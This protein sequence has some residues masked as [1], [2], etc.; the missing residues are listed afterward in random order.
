MS[1]ETAVNETENDVEKAVDEEVA[2][3]SEPEPEQ[4]TLDEYFA[5]Q[6]ADRQKYSNNDLFKK[7]DERK[8]DD[9]DL[10]RKGTAHVKKEK[11]ENDF[12]VL[13]TDKTKS[14]KKKNQ[15]SLQRTVVGGED[16]G[17]R[18]PEL[19][20]RSRDRPDN[21]NKRDGGRKS[22]RGRGGRGP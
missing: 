6:Q 10:K 4:F 18:A 8:V 19:E 12:V 1:T 5:K 7:V 3:E 11:L 15:R 20:R 13:Q 21:F 17:F 16:V 9:N 14:S 22:N 2:S